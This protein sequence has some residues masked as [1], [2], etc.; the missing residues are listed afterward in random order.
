MA[1]GSFANV[2]DSSRIFSTKRQ[3]RQNRPNRTTRCRLLGAH[4]ARA[5]GGRSPRVQSGCDLS[6]PCTR[7]ISLWSHLS[8]VNVVVELPTI[9]RDC[10]NGVRQQLC[11]SPKR[12][13]ERDVSA[14]SDNQQRG[15]RSRAGRVRPRERLL[16]DQQ[17]GSGPA[18]SAIPRRSKDLIE[19]LKLVQAEIA[20]SPV[21]R[22]VGPPDQCQ[23][24]K[25]GRNRQL[26]A[27]GN[28]GAAGSSP[29]VRLAISAARL[30]IRN[31]VEKLNSLKPEEQ[32]PPLAPSVTRL[33]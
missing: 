15:S 21:N 16:D 14:T 11:G 9:N 5:S 17:P 3:R 18:Y 28:S 30:A 25:V 10:R 13:R 33:D 7:H 29:G 2:P 22:W 20:L 31:A 26:V 4:G 8:Q 19:A 6:C 27:E 1:S 12:D 24:L 23:L 32:L